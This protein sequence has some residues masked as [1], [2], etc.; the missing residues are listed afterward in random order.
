VS[1]ESRNKN[2]LQFAS[3][4]QDGNEKTAPSTRR[5]LTPEEKAEIIKNRLANRPVVVFRYPNGRWN[6]RFVIS[7]AVL[8]VALIVSIYF[9]SR[10]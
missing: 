7:L 5:P 9:L 2:K 6:V 3:K 10:W 4:N 8:L 1:K